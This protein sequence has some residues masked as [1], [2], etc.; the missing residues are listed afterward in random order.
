MRRPNVLWITLE[1][2]RADHTPLYGYD[3]DTT[4]HLRRL[5]ERGDAAV[6]ENGVSASIWTP[7]SSA[8]MLTGTHLS[9][10]TVGADGKGQSKIPDGLETLPELL[11]EAGYETALFSSNSFLSSATGLDRGFDFS[12]F[13]RMTPSNFAGVD[14]V[15]RDSWRCLFSRFV[16]DPTIHPGKL[17]RD[18]RDGK[19]DLVRDQAKRWFETR[20][21][22]TAPFFA[23]AHVFS[24]HH[25]YL[26]PRRYLDAYPSDAR[27]DTEEAYSLVEDLY[28]DGEEIA[29]RVATGLDL[30]DGQWE[31]IRSLYDAEIRFAD[32]TTHE[33]VEAAR[34]RSDRDL[35]IVITADHGD[36]FGERGLISHDLVCHDG[37]IRVPIVTV[38]IDDIADGP[39]QLSQHIDLSYTIA[40]LTGTLTDQFEGRDLREPGRWYAISQRG[41]ADLEGYRRYD[42]EFGADD[43]FEGPL[44]AVR[45]ADYKYLTDG[46]SEK[47]YRLP[48]ER[49]N[50]LADEP[51]TASELSAVLE[52]EGI[53]WSQGEGGEE[54]TFDDG[55]R[56]RLRDLGYMM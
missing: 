12:N 49:N 52:L 20:W 37:L 3:R 51:D 48:D 6:L 30:T 39:D 56:D 13:V 53:E 23:Y 1:S 40:A 11:S 46:R 22:G 35:V 21:S 7:P 33:I 24:P 9:T 47:L 55:T 36:L 8:S 2:V 10:H 32:R 41:A 5:C 44:T 14:E 34:S 15:A 26:P 31:A 17:R 50:V 19:N 54:A 28:E 43:L 45:T 29:R 18:V 16:E 4:P 38:G 25:P 27:L 42:P